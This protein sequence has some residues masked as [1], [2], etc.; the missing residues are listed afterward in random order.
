MVGA[1]AAKCKANAAG[2]GKC[3]RDGSR[4]VSCWDTYGLTS[5]GKCVECKVRGEMG[6]TCTK[7]KGNDPSFCL[8]CEDYEGYQPTGV[9]ATKGGRCKSCL[10]KSCNRCAAIT[11]TC[12]ECNRGFGLLASKA[13]K[14]CA[15]DNCITCDGNVRRCTLCYSGHA[16]D[17]NGKCIPC[18]D[19]HC[20]VC[21]KT[22]G[23]CEYCTVGY[24]QVRGRCVVDSKAAAP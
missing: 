6:W 21:S 18:T 15:D 16:P 14:A 4:C 12:Q 8:K 11:G 3:S 23:K 19:K 2:C 7:C 17:K 20:D 5:S 1:S 9:F 10:D 13:C 24:K 22:A